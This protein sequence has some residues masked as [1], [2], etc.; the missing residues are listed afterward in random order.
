[1]R[2]ARLASLY[3]LLLRGL[4]QLAGAMLCGIAV[5]VAYDVVLRAFDCNRRNRPA[6]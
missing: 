5:L 4:A 1:M 3:I 2:K 6:A